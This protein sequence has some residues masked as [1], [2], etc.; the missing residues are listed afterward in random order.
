MAQHAARCLASHGSLQPAYSYSNKFDDC[1]A[2]QC[3]AGYIVRPNFASSEP[4]KALKARA[5]EIRSKRP[6]RY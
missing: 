4:V 2:L 1:F 3:V 6:V 5:L